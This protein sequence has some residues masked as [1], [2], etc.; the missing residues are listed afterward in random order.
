[1]P[2][3]EGERPEARPSELRVDARRNQQR[4]LLAA[5][6]L[7]ADDPA[8]SIQRIA[9]E[10]RVARPTVY[11]RYP[12][13]EALV[14]AIRSE[15]VA[16]FGRSMEQATLRLGDAAEAIGLLVHSL[17]EIGAKYPI[18]FQDADTAHRAAGHPG[19]QASD[20]STAGAGP[21]RPDTT[22]IVEQFNALILRGRREGTV[23]A[24]LAP[25]ILRHSLLGALAA[26]LKLTRTSPPGTRLTAAQV[27][28]QVAA[29]LVEGLRPRGR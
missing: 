17:A 13:R 21:G 1:M 11:R 20:G 6:R 3:N 19:A 18:L 16:E 23:R 15:A 25:E 26:G 28:A 8:A 12:T 4:I 9:D 22:A 10:A 5:A 2:A 7:L 27:G 29:M 24:D 14:E